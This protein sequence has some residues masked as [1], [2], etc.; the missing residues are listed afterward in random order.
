MEWEKIL[1]E[2]RYRDHSVVKSQ[3]DGR[4]E[5]ENDYTRLIF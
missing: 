4:N 3:L 5:F 2:G 1:N